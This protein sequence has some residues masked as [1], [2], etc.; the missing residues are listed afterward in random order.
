MASSMKKKKKKAT[1]FPE[2]A[3]VNKSIE[4][5]EVV[6]ESEKL[7]LLEWLQTLKK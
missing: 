7:Q 1:D 2:T 3:I 6:V 4:E 5:I